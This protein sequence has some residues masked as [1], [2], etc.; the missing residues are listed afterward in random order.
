MIGTTW[1]KWTAGAAAAVVLAALPAVGQAR[2]HY[3]GTTPASWTLEGGWVEV[4]LA[5]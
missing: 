5:N 1:M 2:A 3:T 4:L